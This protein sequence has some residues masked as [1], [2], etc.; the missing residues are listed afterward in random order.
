MAVV[1]CR[2]GEYAKD[3]VPVMCTVCGIPVRLKE[4]S[5]TY[6]VMFNKKT[7]KFEIHDS[8]QPDTTLACE[9]PYDEL[10]A[11][12][13][14]YVREHHVS[15]LDQIAMEID[16]YNDKLVNDAT[17]AHLDTA[18]QKMKETIRYLKAHESAEE[19]P[20]EIINDT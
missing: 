6:F 18:G 17:A 10:D 2:E 15:R 7:Q 8:A 19:I 14:E 3:R 5:P 16:A 13:L 12:A 4:I 1:R 11:R 9:L 20:E